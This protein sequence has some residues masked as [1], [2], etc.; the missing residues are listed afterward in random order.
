[1]NICT[2]IPWFPS[3]VT[4]DNTGIYQYYQSRKLVEMGH[5]VVVLAVRRR[6]MPETELVDGVEVRRFP[7][8]RLPVIRYDVPD[9]PRLNQLIRDVHRQYGLDVIEFFSSDFLTSLPALYIRRKTGVPAVM[10]VNGL[11][12]ISWHT[13]S[14]LLD[15]LSRLYTQ[16]IGLSLIR[17]AAGVRLLHGGLAGELARLGVPR[18][19]MRAIH[20]GVD[21]AVFSPDKDRRRLRAELALE[22]YDFVVLF[23]G[24][25]VHPVAMKGAP[26]LIRAVSGLRAAYPQLKLVMVGDGDARAKHEAMAA[27][28]GDRVLFTGWREDV[29]RY[30]N[31]ADVLVLP[32]L[33]EGCPGVVLEASSCG[34]PVVASRVGAVPAIVDDGATGII[35]EPRSV[36][37]IQRALKTL[38]D[39]PQRRL[40]MGRKGREKAERELGWDITCRDLER[41]Y[42]EVAGLAR[43]APSPRVKVAAKL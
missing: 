1:M 23:V 37:G 43:A 13:G 5:K 36:T 9:L 20:Q 24:R 15:L 34:V 8:W 3:R 27:G 40:E 7:A 4:G 39:S 2:V 28:L 18:H 19:R 38:L 41:L 33:S 16:T 6:G 30:L 29:P 25:L 26:D 11:P 21:T 42:G 22:Q 32:S 10:V 12:G 31:A 35:I 17:R 14:R